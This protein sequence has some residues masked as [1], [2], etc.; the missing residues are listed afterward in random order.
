MMRISGNVKQ[1][2]LVLGQAQIAMEPD[3]I[4]VILERNIGGKA[5]K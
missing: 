3:V 4:N 1:R 2:E 5:N